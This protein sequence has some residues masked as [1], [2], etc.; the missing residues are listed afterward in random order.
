MF[1]N[2]KLLV[3][4]LNGKMIDFCIHV[5]AIFNNKQQLS[6]LLWVMLLNLV[7]TEYLQFLTIFYNLAGN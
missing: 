3:K 4:K 1:K 6:H 2:N 5:K 7:H